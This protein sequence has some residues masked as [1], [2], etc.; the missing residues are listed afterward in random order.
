METQ[1]IPFCVAPPTAPL[2]PTAVG[3]SFD[4]PLTQALSLILLH[5][6]RERP[7]LPSAAPTALHFREWNA[8]HGCRLHSWERRGET[9]T[10]VGQT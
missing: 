2:R 8:F 7:G 3:S 6:T 5:R 1:R 4:A 10:S 9:G